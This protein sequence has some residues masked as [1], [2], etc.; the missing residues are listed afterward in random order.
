MYIESDESTRLSI[1]RR[2][3]RMFDAVDSPENKGLSYGLTNTRGGF[4]AY[5]KRPIRCGQR[6][7]SRKHGPCLPS[8]SPTAKSRL[9]SPAAAAPGSLAG[10]R[11]RYDGS[12]AP[13]DGG[14]ISGPNAPSGQCRW[15]CPCRVRAH[16]SRLR[17][18]AASFYSGGASV[19]NVDRMYARSAFICCSSSVSP[20]GGITPASLW[21]PLL[22]EP[23][24]ASSDCASRVWSA[25]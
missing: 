17:R 14:E 6:G 11:G 20:Q 7:A 15:D 21:P 16:R 10:P 25:T 2:I 3:S 23:S 8:L 9:T 19:R 5:G 22:M 18:R 12:T 4:S 13:S 1:V 24:N